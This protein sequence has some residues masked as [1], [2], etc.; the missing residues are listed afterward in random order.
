MHLSHL[1][2]FFSPKCSLCTF[3]V[4]KVV[5]NVPLR[6]VH[7]DLR[8]VVGTFGVSEYILMLISNQT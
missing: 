4:V 3:P 2:E 1:H 5:G 6:P 7:P 8:V